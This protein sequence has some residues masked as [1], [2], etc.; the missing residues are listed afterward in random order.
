MDF[1]RSIGLKDIGTYVSM[2]HKTMEYWVVT[3]SILDL[4]QREEEMT[5]GGQSRFIW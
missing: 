2:W 4:H 3:R 1:L 5:V